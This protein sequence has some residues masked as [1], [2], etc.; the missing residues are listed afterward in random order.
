MGAVAASFLQ[1]AFKF[2]CFI[3]IAYGGII[4]GKKFRDSKDK[5]KGIEIK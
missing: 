3:V 4:C 2:I 5:K 1:T